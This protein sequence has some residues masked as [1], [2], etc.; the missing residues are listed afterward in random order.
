MP[1]PID[2]D[3]RIP[4]IV[5][6]DGTLVLTDT[7]HES[8]AKL[9]FANPLRAL[10]S[11]A[12]IAQG[13]AAFKRRIAEESGPDAA[14]LPYRTALIDLLRSEKAR[15]RKIHLVTAAD[16][17]IADAV[18]AETG[19]FDSATGS[20][21]IDNLKEQIKLQHLRERFPNGFIYAGDHAADLPIFDA[22]C[23]VIL[24]DVSA[25][26]AATARQ[27]T[28]ILA[29]LRKPPRTLRSWTRLFR[30]HQWSKNILIFVPLITGHAFISPSKMVV[31]AL[32][33]LILCVVSSATYIVNDLADLEADRRH[34]TKRD[35]PFATGSFP[36][37]FGLVTAPLMI[38]GGMSAA[39]ILSPNFAVVLLGYLVLTTAYS[40][41]L[42]QIPL[43]DVF[44]IGVLFTLRI[45]MGTELVGLSYSPWLM[46]Y[47]MAF[48]LSLALAKR[49]GEVMRAYRSETTKVYGRGYHSDDW[50]LTLAFGIGVGL[51]SIVIMLLYLTN[52]A[53][54]SGFYPHAAWLY[55]IP[56]LVT[57]WLMRIWLLANRTQL[58]DDPVVF[59]L[60]DPASI[61]LGVLT[62]IAFV[63]AL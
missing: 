7:L 55:A 58:H 59:S 19:L 37:V 34:L 11:L 30:I 3:I 24:C 47:S 16:Q 18:A 46:S 29:K 25:R 15:G 5:D 21:G 31:G 43:L 56:A 27:E 14:W 36:V 13:R 32:G 41:R 49:H 2:T 22:A 9:L 17:K 26:T 53:A 61:F 20:N 42:K 40:F 35:R 44:V 4:L 50:P 10:V 23:G 8:F 38:I 6:L 48:F 39:Y 1:N 63:L 12:S 28:P 51:V 57:M 45:V 60:R 33:C 62:A 52:D 54:P